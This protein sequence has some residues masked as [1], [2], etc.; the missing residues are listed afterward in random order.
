[1]VMKA[2][3]AKPQHTA[4]GEIYAALQP[5]SPED[6]RVHARMPGL[7]LP[8]S[9]GPGPLDFPAFTT[10]YFRA[11]KGIHGPQGRIKKGSH[12]YLGMSHKAHAAYDEKS[13]V[14]EVGIYGSHDP[15]GAYYFESPLLSDIAPAALALAEVRPERHS[16]HDRLLAPRLLAALGAQALVSVDTSTWRASKSLHDAVMVTY[17][18]AQRRQDEQVRRALKDL[19]QQ[20]RS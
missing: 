9:E 17:V 1:M 13:P 11:A 20:F 12:I 8:D 10:H 15:R 19:G 16:A 4:F 5:V 6:F 18:A 14:N 3:F 7:Y 2:P